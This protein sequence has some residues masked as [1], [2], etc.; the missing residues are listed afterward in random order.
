MWRF[1]SLW[2]GSCD[3]LDRDDLDRDDLDRDGLYYDLN[4]VDI[5]CR[6]LARYDLDRDYLDHDDLDR[7]DL[8]RDDL[9]RVLS[10]MWKRVMATKRTSIPD[11]TKGLL[12]DKAVVKNSSPWNE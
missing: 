5:Y 9:D 10:D 3:D 7:D 4:R 11:P 1:R 2:F 6:D 12:K 8:Y